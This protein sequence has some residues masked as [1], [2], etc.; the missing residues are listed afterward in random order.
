MECKGWYIYNV[1]I[2]SDGLRVA[3]VECKVF[4]DGNSIPRMSGLRVAKVECKDGIQKNRRNQERGLRAPKVDCKVSISVR[5]SVF[6]FY[7]NSPNSAL[8]EFLRHNNITEIWYFCIYII[9]TP[10][11]QWIVRKNVLIDEGIFLISFC[12]K[13]YH[14]VI[15]ATVISRL[16]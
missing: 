6:I 8:G 3:K 2:F 11:L 1:A 14:Q 4:S 15:Y 7:I 5:F 16:S 13:L 12:Y 10:L 9:E